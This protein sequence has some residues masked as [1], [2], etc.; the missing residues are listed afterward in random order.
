MTRDPAR[1]DLILADLRRYWHAAPDLRL[2]QMVMGLL[3]LSGAPR[4]GEFHAEDDKVAAYLAAW[5]AANPPPDH[6]D[7]PPPEIE[8][9]ITAAA[10]SIAEL[11]RRADVMAQPEIGALRT[12]ITSALAAA[13]EEGHTMTTEQLEARIRVLENDIAAW[14]AAARDVMG[15]RDGDVGPNAIRRAVE[16]A[17]AGRHLCDLAGC[18]APVTHI[19]KAAVVVNRDGA[20]GRQDIWTCE[21]HADVGAVLLR[22]VL[23][24]EDERDAE[25]AQAQAATHEACAA[26]Q[27][28]CAALHVTPPTGST[29]CAEAVTM[30]VERVAADK[31]RAVA[32]ALEG[33]G[34]AERFADA[35]CQRVGARDSGCGGQTVEAGTARLYADAAKRIDAMIARDKARPTP[36]EARSIGRVAE[37][38]RGL[39]AE[40]EPSR[41]ADG[42]EADRMRT[43]AHR[44]RQVAALMPDADEARRLV[45]ALETA[46]DMWQYRDAEARAAA[47]TAL[48]RALG[49]EA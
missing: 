44:L 20:T 18:D 40:V 16:A 2:G 33:A 6:R 34:R 4:Y 11:D 39:A 25:V 31:A 47:R 32:A 49:V 3:S 23:S 14:H 38:L 12:A 24:A 17:S 9:A 36:D 46:C 26:L 13:R 21:E 37:H 43:L 1:I 42:F 35:I 22:P 15:T 19:E 45:E 30:V 8:A 41:M 10:W 5:A 27:A 29:Y 28:I 48:L 7:T